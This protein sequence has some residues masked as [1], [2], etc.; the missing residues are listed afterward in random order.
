MY[1]PHEHLVQV[2]HDGKPE[3]WL[4]LAEKAKPFGRILRPQDV[5]F[6]AAYLLSD[7]SEMMTGSLIDFDQKVIGAWD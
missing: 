2:E 5:A 7:Q 3:N 4:E 6:L 1:T